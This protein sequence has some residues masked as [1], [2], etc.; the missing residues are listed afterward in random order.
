MVRM[1]SL[2]GRDEGDDTRRA[3]S[4]GR[5]VFLRDQAISFVVE[6]IAGSDED[7]GRPELDVVVISEVRRSNV[8]LE[9]TCCGTS[10]WGGRRDLR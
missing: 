4:H 3:P 8:E 9:P 2:G 1:T 6:F 10:G 5:R 7:L